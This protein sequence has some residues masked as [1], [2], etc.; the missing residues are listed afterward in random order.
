MSVAFH[1]SFDKY[2]VILMLCFPDYFSGPQLK[3]LNLSYPSKKPCCHYSFSDMQD[4][5]VLKSTWTMSSLPGGEHFF[6]AK[7]CLD[8]YNII[9]RPYNIG[10]WVMDYWRNASVI[11]VSGIK[12]RS[13]YLITGWI[14]PTPAYC[15]QEKAVEMEYKLQGQLLCYVVGWLCL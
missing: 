9:C 14:Y 2:T 1:I 7:D 11:V 12:V 3:W 4:L 8:I 5:R 10:R 13:H 15:I 6:S